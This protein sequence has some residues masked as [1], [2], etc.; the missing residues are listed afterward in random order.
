MGRNF[1]KTF[2]DDLLTLSFSSCLK[3][4]GEDIAPGASGN[5]ISK[6][7]Q[8][9]F[10]SVVDLR[11]RITVDTSDVAFGR[12]KLADKSDNKVLFQENVQLL[13]KENYVPLE[14][15]VPSEVIVKIEKSGKKVSKIV[16][17]R[18]NHIKI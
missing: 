5:K 14:G 16:R 1:C 6:P 17:V 11:N 3:F 8:L 10:P 4:G 9:K 2:N 18:K 12:L 15:S 13:K 7:K